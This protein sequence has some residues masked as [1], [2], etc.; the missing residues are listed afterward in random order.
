MEGIVCWDGLEGRGRGMAYG[1]FVWVG[2]I[3]W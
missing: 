2:R 1:M 3:M